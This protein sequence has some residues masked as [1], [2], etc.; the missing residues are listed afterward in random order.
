MLVALQLLAKPALVP[1]NVTVL[2]PWADP[3]LLPAIVTAEPTAP[4]AGTRLVIVGVRITVKLIPL[5]ATPPTVTTTLPVV[6]PPGTFTVM[7][8]AVQLVAVPA[9]VPLNVTVLLP[10]ADPKLLPAI[11]TGVPTAA[12][13]GVRL[14]IEGV[15]ITVKITPLLATPPTVTTTMP[16]VAPAGTF[17]VM[18]LALQLAAVPALVPLNVTVLLPWADPKLL[19]AIV[20]AEPTAPEVG[21]RLVIEGVGSTVKFEPLL[22]TP[23]TVTTTLPVVAPA[24]TFTVMLVA[25]QLVA[26]PALVPLNVTVLLPCADPKLLPA[27]V[28]GMPTAAEA[29]VRLVIEGVGITV[30]VTPLLATPPAVTT[31]LPVVAPLGTFTVML[32]ALQLVAVPALVPLNVTVLLPWAVPKLLPAI[33]TAEPTAPEAG[34]RPVMTGT[35]AGE[36]AATEA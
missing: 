31:T 4:E 16:V 35:G 20:T 6:A 2:L 23:P 17:T 5:L 14:V 12:E 26:V 24:G 1:L 22:G 25:L 33:V 34:V 32:V 11:V 18:L 36:K 7:L 29:G 28:T 21:V 30:K 15:G 13:A 9:L 27:I 19:P 8:V 10:C 3:K